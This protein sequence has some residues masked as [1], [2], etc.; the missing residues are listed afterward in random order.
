MF[1]IP[2]QGLFGDSLFAFHQP[3]LSVYTEDGGSR[4]RTRTLRYEY[5]VKDLSS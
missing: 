3:A 5:P 1:Q 2:E 4:S